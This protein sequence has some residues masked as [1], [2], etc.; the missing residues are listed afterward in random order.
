MVQVGARYHVD[1]STV[2]QSSPYAL[3]LLTRAEPESDHGVDRKEN[4]KGF[5]CSPAFHAVF[6]AS[7]QNVSENK[8]ARK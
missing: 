3:F 4:V 6:E 8:F 2:T 7:K 5:M 1:H